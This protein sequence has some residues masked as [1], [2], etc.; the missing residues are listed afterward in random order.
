M[1]KTL[2]QARKY[3]DAALER[4]FGQRQG[5]PSAPARAAAARLNTSDKKR[6]QKL[7]E[8]LLKGQ[9]KDAGMKC[10]AQAQQLVAEMLEASS[11][12]LS[13]GAR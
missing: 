11:V 2:L 3:E 4:A 7:V 5:A 8:L 6:L 12:P 9:R 13:V 1:F 10:Y